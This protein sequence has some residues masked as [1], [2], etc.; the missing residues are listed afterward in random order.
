M[1]QI[2]V[3]KFPLDPGPAAWNNLLPKSDPGVTLDDNITSDWLVIGAGFAG[4]AAVRRLSQL[5]PTDRIIVLEA[6]SV[7]EGPAGRNSGF[8][9]DLPHDLTSADYGG[10]LDKDIMLTDDNR[11][12]IQFAA[13]M[14]ADFDMGQDIFSQSGKINGA[15]T[16]KG[17]KHN[18]EYAAHLKT[19]G[20]DYQMLD[21]PDM[22]EVTGTTYYKS[23]LFTA[24]T[25]II[26]PAAFVRSV[27]KGL[28]SNLVQIFENSP[29]T[30]LSRNGNW[31]AQ[32][33]SGSV[34]APKI[35][36]AVNG[37]LNSFGFLPNRLIHVFTYASMTRALSSQESKLLGGRS[38]WGITPADP[39]GTTVRRIN[40]SEGH[41]IVV[42]NRF[43]YDPSMEVTENRIKRVARDH[44]R[45]F[46]ARF[47]M[48]S[49][50]SMQYRWGGR[51]CLSRNNVSVVRQLEDGLYSACCQNG[52]GTTRGTLS[53]LLA[54]ELA[55]ETKSARLDRA[56]SAP[57]PTK[58]LPQ[59]LSKPGAATLLKWQ[60][61]QAGAEL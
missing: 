60:E 21:A 20:E 61:L 39:M 31:V 52:L 17:E 45:A 32:T 27:S 11:H 26:Q 51:L 35:I 42:R 4:L 56:L 23:G 7:A 24:G 54:A 53:G 22:K 57:E 59:F 25:A 36:L 12:A 48:L 3:T 58:L 47:P 34:T 5:C 55:T 18:R 33:P 14:A 8:M 16:I 46:Q 43:T 30:S 1:R 2:N 40:S 10:A 38:V 41:R 9:I 15:A 19:M 37:H 13:D 28:K 29:V 49:N 44:D 6:R 50:I